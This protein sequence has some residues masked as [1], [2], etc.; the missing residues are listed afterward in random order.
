MLTSIRRPQ[1]YAVFLTVWK[2][3]FIFP[4]IFVV[5][6]GPAILGLQEVFRVLHK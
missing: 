4:A 5:S 6:V 1:Y 3:L 2:I